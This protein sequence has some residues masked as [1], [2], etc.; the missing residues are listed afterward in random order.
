MRARHFLLFLGLLLGSCSYEVTQ[1]NPAPV[2]RVFEHHRSKPQTQP[3]PWRWETG[4][5]W[6]DSLSTGIFP[7]YLYFYDITF[8]PNPTSHLA[9]TITVPQ[10]DS[11]FVA[12]DRIEFLFGIWFTD[13][14]VIEAPPLSSYVKSMMRV[15]YELSHPWG[16]W[17]ANGQVLPDSSGA[18]E[19]PITYGRLVLKQTGTLG[20]IT[21]TKIAYRP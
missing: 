18:I 11:V 10:G 7:F 1:L 4:S 21:I 2:Q 3:L 14:I 6:S 9:L 12:N 20:D 5:F 19:V 15:E 13:S 16:S 8:P 17:E